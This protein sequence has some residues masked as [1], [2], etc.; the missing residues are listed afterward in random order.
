MDI[1]YLHR[2]A[3]ISNI[4]MMRDKMGEEHTPFEQLDSMDTI[5]LEI[6]QEESR[7]AW[8]NFLN[9]GDGK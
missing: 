4:Q 9:K 7:V 1:L 3:M 2:A 8:N 5:G 6:A